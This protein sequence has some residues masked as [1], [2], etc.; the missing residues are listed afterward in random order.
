MVDVPFLDVRE[1]NL[2]KFRRRHLLITLS[3]VLV[4]LFSEVGQSYHRVEICAKC[5]ARLST[6]EL[7]HLIVEI[8]RTSDAEVLFKASRF[9]EDYPEFVCSHSWST[10]DF[11]RTLVWD[12]PLIITSQSRGY[13]PQSRSLLVSLY[14]SNGC[15][16][17]ELK[18]FESEG[19][20][21]RK[22]ILELARLDC[23]DG[24]LCSLNPFD[25]GDLVLMRLIEAFEGVE[26]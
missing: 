24:G 7:Q 17:C 9:G 23:M 10:E 2:M 22:R 1:A 11:N 3:L 26:E 20:V 25:S 12:S 16:R 14:N 18:Y 13:S 5:D 21:T 19:H 8:E 4:A 15:L 6:R